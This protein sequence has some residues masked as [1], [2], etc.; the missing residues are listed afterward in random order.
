MRKLITIMVAMV[1]VSLLVAGECQKKSAAFNRAFSAGQAGQAGQYALAVTLA[2]TNVGKGNAL[3][4]QAYE[5][6]K[7]KNFKEAEALYRQSIAA[8]SEQY[9]AYNS[10]G[11]ILALREDY[12][13]A[14]EMFQKSIEVNSKATDSGAEKRV[15]TAT[16]NLNS[17]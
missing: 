11:T 4:A 6:L 8:D 13:G 16:D 12:V 3:N 1:A 15:K 10:L 17:I 14:K 7:A 5:L 2:K 9:W